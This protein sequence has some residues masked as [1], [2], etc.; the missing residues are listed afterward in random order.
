MDSTFGSKQQL[1]IPSAIDVTTSSYSSNCTYIPEPP[2]EKEKAIIWAFHVL[3][4]ISI[5]GSVHAFLGTLPKSYARPVK[6][7]TFSLVCPIVN[8]VR[9]RTKSLS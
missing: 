3:I 9:L 8:L 2:M 1:P 7:S 6:L 4:P 5:S